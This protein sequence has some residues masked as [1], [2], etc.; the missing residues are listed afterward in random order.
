MRRSQSGHDVLALRTRVQTTGRGPELRGDRHTLGSHGSAAVLAHLGG[1]LLGPLGRYV[2]IL[3]V[4]STIPR[5]R[6]DRL[7][8]VFAELCRTDPRV[9]LV[10]VGGVFTEEQRAQAERLGVTARILQL[11]LLSRDQLIAVYHRAAVVVSTSEREGF[12]LPVVE[13]LAAGVPVVVP[14]MRTRYGIESAMWL[15]ALYVHRL[16]TGA[17]KWLRH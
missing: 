13:A 17:F 1:E 4:G 3:H 12:C 10:R 14:D 11:P 9:R 2:D 15:P 7:L 8:E 6:I 16:V 5:K